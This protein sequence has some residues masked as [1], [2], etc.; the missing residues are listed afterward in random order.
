MDIKRIGHISIN[1]G[2]ALLTYG[3]AVGSGQLWEANADVKALEKISEDEEARA[4]LIAHVTTLIL[5]PL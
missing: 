1:V 3:I 4:D 2:D 5:T